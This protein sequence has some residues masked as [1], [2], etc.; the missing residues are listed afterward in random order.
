MASIHF[1]PVIAGPTAS[2]KT[3]LALEIVRRFR[4]IEIVSADSR[5]VYR[6]LDIGTA[7]PSAEELQAVPHHLIDIVDPSENYTAGDYALDARNV[8]KAIVE[9]GNVPLVVGGSGFYIRALF[10]G[11]GAPTV[12]QHIYDRVVEQAQ[13]EGFETVYEELVR[14]DPVAAAAHSPNNRLKV[15]RALACYRQTGRRY[16]DF[17]TGNAIEPAPFK[18]SYRV[19]APSRIELY[20]TINQRVISMIEN[21]LIDEVQSLLMA[22]VPQDAPGL[23]TVGY[24]ETIQFLRGEL[25]MDEMIAAIQ[26]ATRRYAKRQMT[27]FR[28]VEDVEWVTSPDVDDFVKWISAGY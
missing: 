13:L 7:K 12:D 28:K 17:V 14:V 20:N 15:Y 26:Q 8:I 22:G 19:L 16:S 4:S 25:N 21:G 6:G 5:V 11:L 24:A 9:R 23:R 27:W 3:G 10:Q 18:P 1:V 2:G